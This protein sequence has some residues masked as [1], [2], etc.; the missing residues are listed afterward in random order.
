MTN[1][2]RG[3]GSIIV[4]S[5]TD[6]QIVNGAQTTASLASAARD[7]TLVAGAVFV[8]MKLSVVTP[9][10]ASDLI[11]LISRFANSQNG[12][13]PSDFFA[14]HAFHRRIE[15]Q[16]LQKPPLAGQNIT[17][18]A[19]QQSCRT[20]ALEA[21]VPI[22]RGFDDWIET[23]D[24]RR[25]SKREQRATGLID[26]DLDSIKQVLSRNFKYW[27]SLRGFCRTKRILLPDDETALVPACL[28][29]MV[30]SGKQAA[31][32]LQLAERAVAAGWQSR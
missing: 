4:T 7:K 9:A 27:E 5:A 11:P 31:Q 22:V 20:T 25:A 32:L 23:S 3:D 18:W 28:P 2:R 12:V 17:E 8:P 26:R 10:V 13:R 15:E 6:L 14:N 29:S 1:V 24:D 30:P 16:V 21:R 19:K